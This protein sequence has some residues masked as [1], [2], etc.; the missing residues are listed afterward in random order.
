MTASSPES[1]ATPQ[2]PTPAQL[3]AT[4]VEFVAGIGSHRARLLAR[5][6]IRTPV[7]LAF[8]FPRDYEDLSDHR[9]IADL[10]EDKL[11]TVCGDVLEVDSQSSGFGKSRVGVLIR[12]A[13]GL[14]RAIWFNQ[15]FMS[16]KFQVG[17][18]VLLSAKPRLRG[19]RWEM[20]HPRVRWLD[21][22]D[23]TIGRQ[24]YPLYSLTEGLRQYEVRRMV[25]DVLRDVVPALDEVF[26]N[27]L[28]KQYNLMPLGDALWAIHR[29]QNQEQ[30]DRARRRFVFQELF[31]LQLALAA[32]QW[33]LRT[34][35]R[36]PA[37]PS[38]PLIDARIRRRFPFELTAGQR[39]TIDEVVADMGREIP[40]N[41]LL[42]GDVGS[43]KTVVALYA[44]LLAVAHRHQAALVAPTEILAEQHGQTLGKVLGES[45]VRYRL[46]TGSLSTK[47]R[48]Q[49]LADIAAGEVDV[50]IGTHAVLQEGVEFSRLGLVVIDEQHKFGVRQRAVLREGKHSPHYL[51]MTAT[52]IPRTISRALFGDLDVSVLRD[53]PPGRQ[54]VSTYVVDREKQDQW[55]QFVRQ[56]L[57]EGR[58]AFVVVPLVEESENFAAK[59]VSE[60]FE[61][62]TNGE[63]DAFRVGLMHG[64]LRSA[65]KAQ[66]MVEFRRGDVQ[67]LVSTSVIEVGIDIPNATL[68]VVDSPERFGLSQLHQ[69]RG[70]IGRGTHPGYCALLVHD[71]LPEATRQRLDAF[72]GTADGFELAEL[73][74]EMRGPGDLFGTRQ[75]GL[76]PFR[77]ADLRRDRQLLEEARHEAKSLYAADP[78]LSNPEHALLR[79]QMLKR[80]GLVLDLADVG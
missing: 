56:K 20:A 71:E 52:P 31:I 10:E 65:E 25:I 80:Y 60:A 57:R 64:R 43:G 9:Q 63:L 4:P 23:E 41:R 50:V 13:S 72:A 7:D 58:Q 44:I 29:P 68:L 66:A 1:A 36:A 3:L 53:T 30:L 67:V 22:P 78:G 34:G 19:G 21:D 45:R 76:P 18:R 14:M 69:L 40:M 74:F 59:S 28:L 61:S 5:L 51:V 24:M 49:T 17:Q 8:F 26:P 33:Q 27:S 6:D 62:L 15:P 42:Q 12:D 73:D 77:I 47:D 48:E 75:H 79:R 11:L 39:A 55:W 32:R 54:P 70:R 16:E 37:L 46:L 38:T 2:K 35:F